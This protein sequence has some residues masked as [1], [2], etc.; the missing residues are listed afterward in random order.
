M[1]FQLVMPKNEFFEQFCAF[2]VRQS[3]FMG[4]LV[5]AGKALENPQ[6]LIF[7]K[8]ADFFQKMRFWRFSKAFTAK[9]KSPMKKFSRTK[10]AQNCSKH[11]FFGIRSWKTTSR[12]FFGQKSIFQK[13]TIFMFGSLIFQER[14]CKRLEKIFFIK[15]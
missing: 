2:F 10:N 11:S 14:L 1:F 13:M 8:K 7:S 6:N 9:T 5:F 15:F 12:C 3:F 4:L